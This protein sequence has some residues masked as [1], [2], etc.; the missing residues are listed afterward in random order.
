[1]KKE[2]SVKWC[3]NNYLQK[4]TRQNQTEAYSEPLQTSKMEC[5]SVISLRL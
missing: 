4:S 1:M 5:F 3:Q 2:L